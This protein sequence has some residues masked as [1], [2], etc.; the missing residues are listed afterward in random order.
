MA[1]L[2]LSAWVG[3]AGATLVDDVARLKSSWEREGRVEQLRPRLVSRGETIPLAL[4]LWATDVRRESCVSLSILASPRVSFVV[5][6][7]SGSGVDVRT[8]EV[9]S[10]QLHRCGERRADLRRALLEMRSP[11]GI[12]EVLVAESPAPLASLSNVLAHRDPGPKSPAGEAGPAPIPPP[13]ELRAVAWEAQAKRDGATQIERQVIQGE[14]A[15]IPTARLSL[16]EGCHRLSALGLQPS[17]QDPPRDLDLFL[18]GEA[19]SDL[20]REDQS[21]NSDA[22]ISVC[23]AAPAPVRVGVLGLSASDP[24]V[25]QHARFPMPL[26]LPE[27]WGPLLRSR[28]AEAFFRRHSLGVARAPVYESLGVAG[29]TILPLNL[30]QRT[31]YAAGSSVLQGNAKALLLEVTPSDREAAADSTADAESV[32]VAFCTGDEAFARLRVEAV[33]LSVA[34]VTSIWRVE[35]EAV[36]EGAP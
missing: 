5:Q 24:A 36:L 17:A 18:R 28:M 13:L 4:P 6:L 14:G 31:C 25:L 21:E 29:R 27:H 23:L 33:G 16:A 2:I 15:E 10:L 32:V 9:G 22:E 19:L 1:A 34:W 30:E 35:R 26:G 8:S 11:R 3:S 12:V 20:R 7:S